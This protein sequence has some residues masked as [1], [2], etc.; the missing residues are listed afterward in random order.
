VPG[1]LVSVH[2]A[3]AAVID[4]V[5]RLR[6]GV[7]ERAAQPQQGMPEGVLG[8]DR[9]AVSL[10][11]GGRGVGH[12]LAFGAQR[13]P[14]PAQPHLPDTRTPGVA[15]RAASACSTRAGSTPSII[16]WQT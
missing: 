12:H 15:R 3:P 7:N 11:D 1:K 16:R 14:D 6:I 8:L 2:Y 5:T 4:A 10:N 9:D 13:V